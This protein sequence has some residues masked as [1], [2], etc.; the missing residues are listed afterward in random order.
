MSKCLDRC[1]YY[2]FVAYDDKHTVVQYHYCLKHDKVFLNLSELEKFAKHCPEPTPEVS[3]QELVRRIF[4]LIRTC[5]Q[6]FQ[7]LC[8]NRGIKEG[9]LLR[10]DFEIASEIAMPPASEDEFW[11]RVASLAK[12]FNISAERLRELVRQEAKRRGLDPER[13]AKNTFSGNP[14]DS[15]GTIMLL[16]LIAIITNDSRYEQI[17]Q[18]WSAIRDLRHP[19]AHTLEGRS[20]EEVVKALRIF[21]EDYPP[22]NYR[23]LWDLMLQ[24]FEET[25]RIM[26][27]L[28][29]ELEKI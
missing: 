14:L 10:E 21:G 7:L 29:K 27:S 18:V 11:S 15:L 22:S 17:Y 19:K 4:K 20:L 1:R 16:K 6:Q 26:S 25:L 5:N 2:R 28:L 3:Y 13:L 8:K 24:K 23:N 12:L 9:V